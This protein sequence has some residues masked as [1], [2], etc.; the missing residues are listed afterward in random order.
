VNVP[1]ENHFDVII[2]GTG[3]GVRQASFT[4]RRQFGLGW[5]GGG[6]KWR[7][8]TIG[9]PI[10]DPR[11]NLSLVVGRNVFDKSQMPP[12]NARILQRRAEPSECIRR[13]VLNV[14]LFAQAPDS[15]GTAMLSPSV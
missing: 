3:A 4:P 2:I 13:T 11:D 12:M 14:C 9:I 7:E 8:G 5:G 6:A 15:F 10:V 1:Q